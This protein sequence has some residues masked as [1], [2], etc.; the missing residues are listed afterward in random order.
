MHNHRK[1]YIGLHLDES[2]TEAAIF[3]FQRKSMGQ[4]YSRNWSG[5]TVGAMVIGL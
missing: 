5:N 3:M 4:R 1:C 2:S